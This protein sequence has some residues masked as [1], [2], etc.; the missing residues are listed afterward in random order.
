LSVDNEGK[1]LVEFAGEGRR[2]RT[3]QDIQD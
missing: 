3:R 1:V 2:R